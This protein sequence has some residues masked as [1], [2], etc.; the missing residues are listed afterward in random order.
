MH[1]DMYVSQYKQIPTDNVHY[2]GDHLVADTPVMY[3]TEVIPDIIVD[4]MREELVV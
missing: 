2:E 3:Y 1:G 4:T